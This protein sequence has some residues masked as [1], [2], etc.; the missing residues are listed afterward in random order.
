MKKNTSS[1]LVLIILISALVNNS[2]SQTEY[3]QYMPLSVGNKWIYK[4]SFGGSHPGYSY[5]VR[6]EITGDTI[7][8]SKT[9]YKCTNFWGNL[10]TSLLRYDSTSGYL[11]KY[12]SNA[13]CDREY[14]IIQFSASPGD[15]ESTQC[16]T[17]DYYCSNVN[18]TVLFNTNTY[19]KSYGRY[20]TNF[21]CVYQNTYRL[22]YGVGPYYKYN[23]S[24]CRV[25]YSTD[26]E[27]KGASVNGVIYGDTVMHPSQFYMLGT[28][29]FEDNNETVKRGY[30]K[31]FKRNSS[32][33]DIAVLDSVRIR[34][35]GRFTITTVPNDT[36]D[37]MAFDND[38]IFLAT[39]VPTYYSSAIEWQ[40]ATQLY[41]TG[42]LTDIVIKVFRIRDTTQH[43]RSI[44]GSVLLNAQ[45]SNFVALK[46]AYLY[47]KSG[48]DF[49]AYD[50]TGEQGKYKI[51][52]L[53]EGNYQI[54]CNRM[55]FPTKI[56]NITLG[57]N[58]TDIDFVFGEELTGINQETGLPDRFSLSQNYPNPFN[59]VTVFKFG[60]PNNTFTK[61]VVYDLLGREVA[62]L[63]NSQ[64]TA[65]NYNIQWDASAYPSGVYFYRLT[66]GDFTDTKKM[67]LIK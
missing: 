30:V 46:D 26:I 8:N 47:A 58:A 62:S 15:S 16:P 14:K 29:V 55:G 25:G 52:G 51:G 61:L 44:T 63:V 4:L 50:V 18:D 36:I 2:Y 3:S 23:S 42:N 32:G 12:D 56:R 10:G 65:G 57:P 1:A 37:L 66:A 24:F 48:N 9:Y 22:M 64:L 20:T 27:L 60:L 33:G 31:M 49:Y 39:F 13:A 28:V 21:Y 54:I 35:N 5:Y 34:S 41:P 7:L 43:Q 11:V 40:N 38:E 45:S 53:K 67:V 17:L 19:L 59:P 6:S